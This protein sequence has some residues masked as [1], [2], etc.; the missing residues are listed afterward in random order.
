VHNQADLL[1]QALRFLGAQPARAAPSTLEQ[2]RLVCAA[3]SQQLLEAASIVTPKLQTAAASD[4]R[5]EAM[6][7]EREAVAIEI[8]ALGA[9]NMQLWVSLR[10]SKVE[11]QEAVQALTDKGSECSELELELTAVRA[12]S[13]TMRAQLQLVKGERD[14]LASEATECKKVEGGVPSAEEF[15]ELKKLE[16]SLWAS[17]KHLNALDGLVKNKQDAK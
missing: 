3:L 15:V 11:T 13:R 17:M 10:E 4:A 5:L 14:R 12:G 2:A 9:E 1:A 7:A 16:E 6:K 8:Q